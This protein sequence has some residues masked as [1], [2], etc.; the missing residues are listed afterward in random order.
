MSEWVKENLLVSALIIFVVM[1][2]IFHFNKL[3]SNDCFYGDYSRTLL[4]TAIVL[5]IMLCYFSMSEDGLMM[6]N[7]RYR[8]VNNNS[9]DD[10]FMR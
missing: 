6:N 8:V 7:K 4:W 2:V 5:L 10:I 9:L 3:M 1:Y